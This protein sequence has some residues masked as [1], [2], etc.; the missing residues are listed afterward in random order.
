MN[1]ILAISENNVIGNDLDI[2]WDLKKDREFFR[3]KVKDKTVILGTNTLKSFKTKK[4]YFKPGKTNIVISR[5]LK[6]VPDGF[7]L[8]T[9]VE[10]ALKVDPNLYCIGGAKLYNY[11]LKNLRDEIDYIYLTRVLKTF[12][13]NC[14]VNLNLEDFKLISSTSF[15]ENNLSYNIMEYKN[16]CKFLRRDN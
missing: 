5:T 3:E 6:E 10:D 8:S 2:P 16:V 15:T 7:I 14:R 4:G 9:S 12:K 13:G 1:L 11:C